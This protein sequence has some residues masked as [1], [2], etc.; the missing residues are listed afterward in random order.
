MSWGL[1]REERDLERK[2]VGKRY[3]FSHPLCSLLSDSHPA[4]SLSHPLCVWWWWS[5]K[6][7]KSGWGW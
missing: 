3:N 5:M 4:L 7:V 1:S 6:V 2:E